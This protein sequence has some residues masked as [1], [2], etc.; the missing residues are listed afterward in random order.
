MSGGEVV[1]YLGTYGSG[2]VSRAAVISGVPPFL[3]KNADNLDLEGVDQSVFDGILA[4]IAK[5][6]LAYQTSFLR[7]FYNLDVLLVKR[8]SEE[9][10]RDS[11]ITAAGASPTGTAACVPTWY[12]DFRA[13]LPKIDVP[14]LVVHG[15]QDRI[16]PIAAC[17]AKT[18][19]G[20]AGSRYVVIEGAPHGLLW[21]HAEEV[22][23]ALLGFLA[24]TEPSVRQSTLANA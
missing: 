6:R 15:D 18:H 16:L 21:T 11:W 1:R 9:V 2:R 17:G 24:E 20:I 13:D 10:V 12:T 8:I 7:D 3:L 22:N 4:S 19:T 14:T 23:Q 5:D